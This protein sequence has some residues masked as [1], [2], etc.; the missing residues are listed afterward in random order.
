MCEQEKS[1]TINHQ[2]QY[3][4][5]EREDKLLSQASRLLKR[6]TVLDLISKKVLKPHERLP[7]R[8]KRKYVTNIQE[9]QTFSG[10]LVFSPPAYL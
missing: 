9:R 10:I 8:K 3:N 6:A 5:E 1:L 2:N 4:R 7:G